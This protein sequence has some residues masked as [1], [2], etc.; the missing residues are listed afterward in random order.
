MDKDTSGTVVDILK[1]IQGRLN[2]L[3]E[4]VDTIS[5][6]L[7]AELSER[8]LEA[9]RESKTEIPIEV[10]GAPGTANLSK[11]AKKLVKVMDGVG[12]DSEGHM[13]VEDIINH[14]KKH[15]INEAAAKDAL[16]E[17]HRLELVTD[18]LREKVQL[19]L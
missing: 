2:V 9:A 11:K 18:P 10:E 17:L 4:K 8:K 14:A 1:G 3:E 19:R 16:D 6:V 15:H 12:S 5:M 7:G 13:L